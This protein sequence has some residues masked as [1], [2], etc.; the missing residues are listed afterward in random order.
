MKITVLSVADNT[1]N[2]GVTI[3]CHPHNW[4]RNDEFQ[5]EV[6]EIT[7]VISFSSCVLGQLESNSCR[8]VRPHARFQ[9]RAAMSFCWNIFKIN[10]Q[11][12]IWVRDTHSCS[13]VWLSWRGAHGH[14]TRVCVHR[15]L[16]S[17]WLAGTEP[18]RPLTQYHL[19]S[20]SS[21]PEI[22]AWIFRG[23]LP[24]SGDSP[25]EH[26]EVFVDLTLEPLSGQPRLPARRA[27]WAQERSPECPPS[28][29]TPLSAKWL[30]GAFDTL[31]ALTQPANLAF[32]EMVKRLWC[33]AFLAEEESGWWCLWC[34]CVWNQFLQLAFGQHKCWE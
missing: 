15:A 28:T 9:A 22:K 25:P 12:Y 33:V 16:R 3:V 23:C 2:T 6:D 8:G 30:N 11:E 32:A 13:A 17:L 34:C 26:E 20:S 19:H 24:D 10:T 7:D 18:Y 5:L 29:H 21:E 27:L 14:S 4:R 31:G 1:V